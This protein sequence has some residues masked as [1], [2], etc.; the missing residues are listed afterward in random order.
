MPGGRPVPQQQERS[1]LRALIALVLA[2]GMLPVVYL[3]YWIVRQSGLGEGH[4]LRTVQAVTDLLQLQ[5]ALHNFRSRFFVYPPSR[6]KLSETGNYNPDDPLDRDSLAYLRQMWPDL[7]WEDGIDWNGNGKIDV[8]ADGGDVVLEGDQCL[9]F[10][11][12]GIPTANPPGCL[13]FSTNERN[14]A[15]PGGDRR[16]PFFEGFQANPNRLVQ[17]HGNA[18]YSYLDSYGMK[19]YAY[20][21]S[22]KDKKPGGYNRY[23]GTDCA[24]LG[25][26]PYA[27]ELNPTPQYWNP[28]SFQIIS[29]GRDGR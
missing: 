21:S 26:W 17:I 12:G 3:A 22:H 29:A 28:N 10:F 2:L 18:F 15:Q 24:A 27:K 20:F 7:Q 19:P 25:V 14:P 1:P 8:P 9:V 5:L 23:G 6:I 4:D 13:G 16:G 11:L